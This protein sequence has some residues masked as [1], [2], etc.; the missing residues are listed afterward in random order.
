MIDV[1]IIGAG[2]GGAHTALAAA[3]HGLSVVM[4]DE[5][6]AAG[7]Q[8]WRLPSGQAGHADAEVRAGAAMRARLAATPV[9]LL[10]R[11]CV[12]LIGRENDLWRIDLVRGGRAETLRA[13]TL[14]L[15]TGAHE[16]VVPFPG[17]TTP[18]VIGLAA[19]TI[20]LKSDGVLPGRRCVVAGCGPLL[21]AVAAGVLKAGGE[22]VA[23]VDLAARREWLAALAQLSAR[24]DLAA[25]GAGWLAR[26]LRAGAKVLSRHGVIG[27]AGGDTVREVVVAPVDQ[28]GRPL[29]GSAPHRFE[30]DCLAIGH[31]LVPDTAAT[32]L[33]RMAHRY[34]ADRG[35]WFAERDGSL[36]TS[37]PGLWLVGEVGGIGGAAVAVLQGELAGLAVAHAL[38]RL[39]EAS[40]PRD[41]R[42][43]R[44][45]LRRAERVGGAMARM[46]RLRDG[47]VAA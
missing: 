16:R 45:S 43:L 20:L 26:I 6:A 33:L 25:R 12:W 17:W 38:G 42:R 4:I 15:A 36:A 11:A 34:D 21:A 24:P 37:L 31:G 23:V 3:A 5:N 44:V 39:D 32:R 35:G 28:T 2:P 13:S 10:T 40:Y 41:A 1:A 14:V 30:A 22:V 29:P 8:V 46:M 7:G 47:L 27:V 19:A 18:G 9:T